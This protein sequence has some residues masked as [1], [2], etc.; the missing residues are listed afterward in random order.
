MLVGCIAQQVPGKLIWNS[1]KQQFAGN[2]M[3][4]ALLMPHIRKGFEY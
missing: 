3:A 2:D 4:N 1:R